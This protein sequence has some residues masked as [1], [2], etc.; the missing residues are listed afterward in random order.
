MHTETGRLGFWYSENPY[1]PWKQ[2]YYTDYWIVE[3][4]K[5]KGVR[6]GLTILF[7]V[8]RIRR[9]PLTVFGVIVFGAFKTK[10]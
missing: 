3:N 8:D 7:S 9:L 2:L 4:E 6:N 1:G 10:T 5:I